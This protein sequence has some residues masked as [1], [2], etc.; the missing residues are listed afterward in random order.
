MS[1]PPIW[2]DTH[3]KQAA[4][5]G[6][7]RSKH[8]FCPREQREASAEPDGGLNQESV[9]LCLPVYPPTTELPVGPRDIPRMS[10]NIPQRQESIR[11]RDHYQTGSEKSGLKKV[12]PVPFHLEPLEMILWVS[13]QRRFW[14]QCLPDMLDNFTREPS[15]YHSS[16]RVPGW[17]HQKCPI[18]VSRV[19]GLPC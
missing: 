17:W 3:F 2:K 8:I 7:S 16:M 10:I 11:G 9:F 6:P 13:S 5:L 14:K 1:N 4:K 12:K 18:P 19:P 15:F